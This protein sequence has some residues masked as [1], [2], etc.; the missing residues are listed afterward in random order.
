MNIE[1][2]ISISGKGGLYKLLSQSRGGFIVEALA[3]GKRFPVH[4]T[5]NVSSLADIAMYTYE[6]EVPL[7]EVFENIA[8]KENLGPT[9]NHKD[10]AKVLK[11][12]FTD[13]LPNFDEDR[14]YTSD[15]KKV[16]QWYNILQGAGLVTL[17][18][19]KEDGIEDANIVTEE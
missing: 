9:L 17:D 4:S 7:K 3:D 13:V 16:F 12:Y 1:G 8:K 10:S 2:I 18:D 11:E 6:E 14:V 19:E 5:N 15:I